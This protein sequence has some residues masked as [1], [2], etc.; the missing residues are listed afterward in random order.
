[1]VAPE[2]LSELL[3]GNSVGR[4]MGGSVGIPPC[5]CWPLESSCSK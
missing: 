1:V 2:T 4:S 5:S 3:P